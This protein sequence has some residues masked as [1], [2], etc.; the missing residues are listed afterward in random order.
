MVLRDI[1][2]AS[3]LSGFGAKQRPCVSIGWL[4]SR[5]SE[6]EFNIVPGWTELAEQIMGDGLNTTLLMFKH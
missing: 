5:R 4:N 3:T 6:A 2:A 1:R